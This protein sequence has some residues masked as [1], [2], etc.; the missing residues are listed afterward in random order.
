MLSFETGAK[1]FMANVVFK[2]DVLRTEPSDSHATLTQPS[3]DIKESFP[4]SSGH[5]TS[6]TRRS[7]GGQ[8]WSHDGI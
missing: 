2:G 7:T 6:W 3:S 8:V 4:R 5:S 1:L